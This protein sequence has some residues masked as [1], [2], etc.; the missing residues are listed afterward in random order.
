MS[1]QRW[2]LAVLIIFFLLIRPA[3]GVAWARLINFLFGDEGEG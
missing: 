1:G 3:L 2:A